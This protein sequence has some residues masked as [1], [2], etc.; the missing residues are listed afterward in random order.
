MSTA[1][2]VKLFPNGRSQAVRLPQG[3]RFDD[4]VKDVY[5]RRDPVTGDVTISSRPDNWED[6]FVKI[7]AAHFNIVVS[8]EEANLGMTDENMFGAR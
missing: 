4:D 6:L 8:D 5:V 7:N 2:L 1:Q 3:C